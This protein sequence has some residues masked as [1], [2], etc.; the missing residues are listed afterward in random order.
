MERM[1]PARKHCSRRH[2]FLFTF[3]TVLVLDG[4]QLCFG[5]TQSP[6]IPSPNMP[7]NA[8]APVVPYEQG[9]KNI[10]AQG[11]ARP[12]AVRPVLPGEASVSPSVAGGAL[13]TLPPS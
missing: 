6:N 11:A 4:A 9:I 3:V 10:L 8:L 7:T 1:W 5:Q 13:N 2:W 12:Q